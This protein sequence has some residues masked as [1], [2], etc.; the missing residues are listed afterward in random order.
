MHG[1]IDEG[2]GADRDSLPEEGAPARVRIF[3]YQRNVERAAGTSLR[4]S[5]QLA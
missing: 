4:L 1:K 3:V 5:S 2:G